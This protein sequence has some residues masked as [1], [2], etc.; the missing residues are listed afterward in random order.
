MANMSACEAVADAVRS[1]LGPRGMDKL[2]V[3][4]AGKCTVS[5][6]GATLMQLLDVVHPAARTLV[7][8]A[9]AQDAEVGDGTTSVVLL[10]AELLTQLRPLLD[11][12]L[13]P[14]VAHPTVPLPLYPSAYLPLI[15]FL[16]SDLHPYPPAHQAALIL[17]CPNSSSVLFLSMMARMLLL[18]SGVIVI[19]RANGQMYEQV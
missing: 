6:D 1:T 3:D 17:P 18:P 7:Q 19:G 8:I 2:V 4:G 15:L 14:Q 13:H 16:S 5:N 12:G 11:Q 10:A 9:R